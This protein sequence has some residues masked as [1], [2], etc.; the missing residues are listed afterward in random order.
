MSGFTR[1]AKLL[2][3]LQV[4]KLSIDWK[5]AQ[6]NLLGVLILFHMFIRLVVYGCGIKN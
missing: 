5:E 2:N 4:E 6:E 1:G 3:D